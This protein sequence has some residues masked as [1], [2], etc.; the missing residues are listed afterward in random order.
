[1]GNHCE[2]PSQAHAGDLTVNVEPCRGDDMVSISPMHF[3]PLPTLFHSDQTQPTK[4]TCPLVDRGTSQEE[5]KFLQSLCFRCQGNAPSSG[6][7]ES[8]RQHFAYA[9]EGKDVTAKKATV[10][11]SL[12][13]MKPGVTFE[14]KR[15]VPTKGVH[16]TL[17]HRLMADAVGKYHVGIEFRG[18]EFTYGMHHGFQATDLSGDVSSHQPARAGPHMELKTQ[19][20]LGESE[21][22]LAEVTAWV[23]LLGQRSFA[24]GFYDLL[25][26]NCQTFANR[27]L[28]LLGCEALPEW[29]TVGSSIA[30][31]MGCAGTTER[32]DTDIVIPD[33]FYSLST[34][35]SRCSSFSSTGEED[36]TWAVVYG[37][38]EREV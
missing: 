38:I 15:A 11:A 21:A 25:T 13:Y 26:H 9:P 2:C 7:L 27:M 14:G 10:R 6:E 16:L 22:S 35:A 8:I 36:L 23:C 37:Q 4:T 5:A 19:L 24:K 12:Y 32:E 20:V 1:M 29:V 28:D 3:H 33:R 18:R 30:K 34:T 17:G 31:S